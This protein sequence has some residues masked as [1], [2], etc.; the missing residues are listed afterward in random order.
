MKLRLL[1]NADCNRTCKGCCNKDWDLTSL[2]QVSSFAGYDTIIL[3]GG[4]PMLY[5]ELI[6]ATVARIRSESDAPIVLYT[7]WREDAQALAEMLKI[8]DGITLTLHTRKD[9]EPFE[10]LS[11]LV[12]KQGKS[13]RLNVFH[14]VSVGDGDVSGWK[15]KKE[16]RWIKDCPLPEDEVFMRL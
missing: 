6:R 7:A 9:T 3:T 2:P 4:E 8:V 13:L 14:G 15:V 12:A 11:R 10:R 1:L 5:P 16:I